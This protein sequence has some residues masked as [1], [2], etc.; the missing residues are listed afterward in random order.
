MGAKNPYVWI[1]GARRSVNMG[2]KNTRVEIVEVPE[3]ANMDAESTHVEIVEVLASAN[4]VV[5][6]SRAKSARVPKLL[7]TQQRLRSSE[8]FKSSTANDTI[9]IY[10]STPNKKIDN[11]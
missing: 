7:R 6:R 3:S 4:I 1:V 5:I 9:L 11:D 10:I 2:A 8:K